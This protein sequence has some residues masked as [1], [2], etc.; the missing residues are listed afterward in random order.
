MDLVR[1]NAGV[2]GIIMTAEDPRIVA[3]DADQD[4]ASSF[5]DSLGTADDPIVLAQ[6]DGDPV[7]VP[8]GETGEGSG[9]VPI[10]AEIT[11]DDDNV[12]RLPSGVT[13]EELRLDGADIILVQA[14]GTEI[15]IINAALNIPTFVIDGIEVPQEVLVAVLGEN[16]INVAAGPE[17]QLTVVG[18]TPQGSGANFNDQIG[19]G[20]GDGGPGVLNL[21]QGTELGGGGEGGEE[22]TDGSGIAPTISAGGDTGTL[23]ESDDV[24][25][26]TDAEPVPATGTISFFDPDFG[27]TRTAEITART[28]ISSNIVHGPTLTAAQIDAL[29][30][31]FTLDSAASGGVTS[32]PSAAG[33]G[34]VDW[35]YTVANALIDF[36]AEGETIVLDFVVTISDGIND[37]PTT[38][39]ITV[40]G[41]NDI[42]VFTAAD[43]TVV[44]EEAVL[45]EGND[46]DS[47]G[48]GGSDTSPDAL[49]PFGGSL[50][51]T[52]GPDDYSDNA[53]TIV[54]GE[55]VF[56]GDIAWS[57]GTALTSR[58]ED[59][60]I[61]LSDGG[62]TITG[63]AG[64]RVVFIATV[65]EQGN[66]TYTFDLQDVLDHPEANAEDSVT[67]TFG[68]TVTDSND[69][70]QDHSFDV[71]INDDAPMIG[72]P[73]SALVDED[74]LTQPFDNAT[75]NRDVQPG[76]DFPVSDFS[77]DPDGD[78][79]R[80][81]VAGTLGIAWGADNQNDI[82]DGG[83]ETV[84]GPQDGDRAVTFASDAI[85]T[86]EALGLTSQGDDLEYTL[87]PN[88]TVLTAT[89]DDG[90]GPRTVFVVT[91]SDE[92]TGSFVFDLDD[93]LDHEDGSTEDNITLAFNFTVTD[94]DGDQVDGSFT[95]S[96]D[97]DGPV[98]GSPASALVDED[99]LTEPT[100]NATGNRD[101]QPGDDFPVSDFSV[102]PDGD[103]DRTTVA[104]RLDIAWGADDGNDNVDGG[105]TGAPVDGDRAVTF[106]SNA[107]STLEALV[108]T[109][110]GDEVNYALSDD[111]TTLLAYRGAA[112]MSFGDVDADQSI[113]VFRV[114]LS[115][116][117][118]GSY[119]FDLNDVLDHPDDSTEDNIELAFHFTATDS[120][121]DQTDGTFT[122]EVDDDSP[123]FADD[124]DAGAVDEDGLAGGNDGDSY[125][126]G[127]DI[128]G[129]ATQTVGNLNLAWGADDE[130]TGDG[131]VSLL[132][133]VDIHRQD[134]VEFGETTP[135]ADM[136]RAV[137]FSDASV[138][139]TGVGGPITDLTSRG[140]QVEFSLIESGTRLIAMAGGRLVFTVALSDDGTGSYTF[141]LLDELDHPGLDSEDNISLAFNITARDFDGD[142]A[143][144]QFTVTVNDD[145]PELDGASTAT[146]D[147]D[148]SSFVFI[149][150]PGLP[151]SLSGGPDDE[152]FPAG[153]IGLG[154]LGIDWGA[155]RSGGRS[156]A[157]DGIT[158][159]DDAFDASGNPLT[160]GGEQVKLWVD[161]TTLYGYVGNDPTSG[162]PAQLVFTVA[163]DD[164][165]ILN[166]QGSYSFVLNDNLDHAATGTE[167]E[168]TLSFDFRATDADGDSRVGS[169]DVVVDD[170][171]PTVG[172]AQNRTVDEDGG[173]DQ[174][175]NPGLPGSNAGGTD[176][177]NAPV[178]RTGSLAIS[179]GADR[180]NA[181]VNGGLTGAG[182]TPAD[183]DRAVA[184]DGGVIGSLE[185]LVLSSNGVGLAYEL[186]NGNST[187]TAFRFDGAN[188]IDGNGNSIGGVP[189]PDAA[190][191]TVELYDDSNSGSYRFTLHDNLDHAPGGDENEIELLF[192][193]VAYDS[194]GDSRGGDFEITIDD[195]TPIFSAT[196][197]QGTV[198]EDGLPE[199]IGDGQ[200]D[201]AVDADSDNDGDETTF[202][203]ALNIS[204]GAD[205]GD[206]SDTG[207][208]QD[209]P[210]GVGNRSVTFL[211]S[212]D[213]ASPAGLTSNGEQVTYTLNGDG[214]E[215]TASAGGRT[216]FTV[217]LSDDGA[218]TYS[219]TLLDNLDHAEGGDEND[220]PLAFGFT[221]AD[222]DGDTVDGSF[223]VNVDDDLPVIGGASANGVVEEEENDVAGPGIEDSDGSGDDDTF[224]IVQ[225]SNPTTHQ[226]TD[227][228]LNIDWGADDAN[229]DPD[230]G[231]SDGNGDRGLA[232]TNANAVDNITVNGGAILA[233][234]LTS[235]GDI[236]TYTFDNDRGTLIATADAGGTNERV[237]FT[238][239]LSDQGSGSYSFTLEDT[240][241]HP[242]GSGENTLTFTFA[243]TATDSDGD[244]ADST[245]SVEVI[246]DRPDAA[247]NLLP[248]Y[249]E[250]EALANGNEDV[251]PIGEEA[252]GVLYN[253]GLI[254]DEIGASLNIAWGGDDSNTAEN[255]GFD[256]S[257]A[258]GDRS[259]I[260]DVA[261]PA[262]TSGGPRVLSD[263]EINAFLSVSG[264]LDAS[265]LTSGGVALVYALSADNSVLTATAGSGGAV[266]FTVTLSDMGSG[267]WNF[268][269]DGTLDHPETEN[270]PDD[271]NVL[272]LSFDFAARDGDGDVSNA[273][274]AVRIIDDSPVMAGDVQNHQVDEDG[275][276]GNVGDSYAS[277][278]YATGGARDAATV[279]SRSL[280]IL[281]GA[282]N[283]DDAVD[284]A[285]GDTLLQDTRDG[286]GDRSVIFRN[287]TL[288][289]LPDL[290]SGGDDVHF[291]F[292]DDRTILVAHKG[293]PGTDF[294]SVNA[295]DL[296]FRVSL[297]D[298]GA[299][300]YSFEL[301][302]KLD[303]DE[304][305]GA[306]DEDNI[307]LDFNFRAFDS[308][309]D[310]I[311]GSFRVRVDD[312]APVATSVVDSAAVYESELDDGTDFPNGDDKNLDGGGGDRNYTGNL[313]DLVSFG[314]D[315]DGTYIVELTNLA[316]E[317]DALTSGGVQLEYSMNPI[318]SENMLIATANGVEIFNFQVN[319]VNGQYSFR[320]KGPID[321]T[322]GNDAEVV[323]DMSSAV[324]ARDSD[325]DTIALGGQI[326]ITIQDDV[327]NIGSVSN[328]QVFA[329]GF[330]T[331]SAGILD[332]TNG[333]SG[334]VQLFN[335]GDN[336][337]DTATGSGQYALI[338]QSNA[339]GG[340][341]GPFTRFEGYQSDFG[342]GFAA[343]I[344]IY[345][346]PAALAAGEGFDY[347]VAAYNQ[348]GGHLR[349][350]IFHVTK[351]TSTGELLVGG[352]NNTN[353]DPREDL[354]TLDH[355]QV[356]SAGWYR[357]EHVFRDAGDGSLAVD[358]NLYD[359]DGNL[360]FTE[361]RNNPADLIDILVGGHGYG[362]FTNIDVAG[363]IAVDDLMMVETASAPSSAAVGEAADGAGAFDPSTVAGVLG[364]DWGADNH[365]DDGATVDRSVSFDGVAT[366]DPVLSADGTPLT[367]NGVAIL[368]Q[369]SA[370]GTTLE[371]IADDD[372]DGMITGADTRVVFTVALDDGS[373]P[374][375]QGTWNFTLSDNVDH[376]SGG[377]ED[378]VV[379]IDFGFIATDADGDPTAPATFTVTINDDVPSAPIVTTG[380]DE[381]VT[382]VVTL[383][384]GVDFNFGADDVGAS[385]SIGAA[386]VTDGPV[387]LTLGLPAIG[388][389]GGD[390][391]TIT[392]GTAFDA[393]AE[394][395][396][397][398]L[399]IPYTVTDGD[400]DTATDEITVT[401]TGANDAPV[402]TVDAGSQGID[403]QSQLLASIAAG[404][405]AIAGI[406]ADGE[407]LA[408][409]YQP[410]FD[411]EVYRLVAGQYQLEQ[412][413]QGGVAA[414]DQF[415]L[416]LDGGT[417]I[418]GSNGYATGVPFR[419]GM[420]R[421][422][423]LD[424]ND[425]WVQTEE[426]FGIPSSEQS[427]GSSVAVDGDRI[428]VGALGRH[429]GHF[430]AG[431]VFI[432][433]K[434]AGG[435]WVQTV[436]EN[437]QPTSDDYL[438]ISIDLDGDRVI[439]GGSHGGANP[440]GTGQVYV[441]ERDAGGTWTPT[442]LVP[443]GVTLEHI[444]YD[445]AIEGD[446]AVI[447]MHSVSGGEG[448]VAVFQFTGGLWTQTQLL[449]ATPPEASAH[450]GF[451][452]DL[453]GG[454]LAIAAPFDD[455]GGSDRGLIYVYE[456]NAGT[457][458]FELV[459]TLEGSMPDDG[460]LLG[461]DSY[462]T[463][464]VDGNVIAVTDNNTSVEVF[465]DVAG[466]T[467][468][469]VDL[470]ESD[471]ALT[472][473]GTVTVT[474][475][476]VTDEVSLAVTDVT[477]GGTYGGSVA[478]IDFAA[479]FTLDPNPVV[480]SGDTSATV[481]WDFDSQGEAFDFL[482]VGETLTISYELVATDDSGAANDD[483]APQTV[484]ITITGTNDAPV[485]EASSDVA[486]SVVES[487][488]I[489]GVT[490]A[491][492]TGGLS[493]GFT[494]TAELASLGTN[495]DATAFADVYADV[496]VEVGGDDAA[497]IAVL[498]A[499]LDPLYPGA[500]APAN[501]PINEA[502][503]RLGAHYAGLL[504]SGQIGPLTEVIAKYTADNNGS[505]APDRMQSLHDNL[506]GNLRGSVLDGRFDNTSGLL[507]ELRGIVD[508]I[509]GV[510]DPLNDALLQRTYFSGN[511]IGTTGN[512]NTGATYDAN[513]GIVAK[514]TGTID[515]SDVDLGAGQQLTFSGNDAGA[516]GSFTIDPV[517]GEWTYVLNQGAADS[518]GEGDNP[519]EVFTV[520][521]EDEHGATDTVDVSVTVTGT[522]DAP[523][524]IE[525]GGDSLPAD[526]GDDYVIGSVTVSDVDSSSFT[527]EVT[528]PDGSPNTD[529]EVVSD[530]SGGYQLQT[531][532]SVTSLP[533]SITI[534][535]D[536]GD[537]GTYSESFVITL[538]VQLFA[539]DQTTLLGSYS[540]IQAAVDDAGDNEFIVISSGTYTEQ[541]VVDGKT[542]LTIMEAPGAD[543][544]I[545]AP[546]DVV[547]TARSS[548][549]REIHS[550]VTVKNS[551]DIEINGV[552]VDG[553]GRANAID[554]GAGAGQANFT[555]VI[556][557]NASGGLTDVDITGVRDPY[558]GGTTAG[559]HDLV[560]GIQ[561]GVALQVDNDDTGPRLAFSM[562]GGSIADFQKNATSFVHADLDI[563]GVVITGGGAQ[564][565]IAQN[566]IQAMDSTGEITGVTITQIG[567]A[568]TS[569]VYSGGM[570]LYDNVD[571]DVTGSTIIGANGE[572]TAAKIVGIYVLNNG[573][574]ID[575]GEISGNSVS[576]V[577]Y[578][579]IVYG[580]IL[581]DQVN[582]SANTV[583]D[584]D[585]TNNAP[586]GIYHEPNAA[587]TT[588]FNVEGSDQ[589]DY[590]AGAAGADT[591]TGLDGDDTLDGR[592]G[593]DIVDGGAGDDTIMWRVGDGGDTIDGGSGDENIGDTLVVESTAPG[594]TIT[595]TAVGGGGFTVFDGTDTV[596]VENVEEV[597][598]DFSAGAGTLN[599]VGDF[600]A[601]GINI[602][603]ITVEGSAGNDTV[604]A[605]EM[606]HSVSTS[607][608]GI[609]FSGNGG[610]DT[611]VSGT[612]DDYFDGGD[613]TDSHEFDA[614]I[615]NY[616]VILNPDGTATITD[617]VG[618][619][620]VD[621]S[622][623]TVERIVFN[624]VTLDLTMAVRLFDAA[625]DSLL[626]TFDSVDDAI[627]AVA[628]Q[629]ATDLRIEVDG[630]EYSATESLD[631]AGA[632]INGKNVTIVGDGITIGEATGDAATL[633]GDFGGGSL[634]FENLTIDGGDNGISADG[635]VTGLTELKLDG[636]TVTGNA[637]HGLYLFET[638]DGIALLTIDGG[639]FTGNGGHD[640]N[641][642]HIKLFGFSGDADFTGG[643]TLDGTAN[644]PAYGIEIVGGTQGGNAN[645]V[646]ANEP[647]IG[648]VTFNGV[649]LTGE[650]AKNAVA[651]YN[652]LNLN[653]L[654]IQDLDLSGA[655]AGWEALFNIDGIAASYDASGYNITYPDPGDANFPAGGIVAELQGDKSGQNP[656]NNT[657]T[658]GDANERLIGKEGN[659]TLYG[660]GGDDELYG[661]YKPHPSNPDEPGND[662]L[663]GGAGNDRMFGGSGDDTFMLI[664]SGFDNG[665]D[666]FD[667]GDGYDRILGG[668]S[669]DVLNVTNNLS[670]LVSIEEIDGASNTGHNTI[671][672]TAGDDTLDF[673]SI[674][675]KQFIIDGAGGNDTITGTNL[676]DTIR[677]GAG[678]DILNGLDGD[679]TFL[680]VTSNFDNGV[681]QYDGGVGYDRIV[682]GW[683]ID[684]LNVTNNLAN[685]VGI[686][687]LEGGDTTLDRNTILATAGNDTLN[688]S[689]M[690]VNN[691]TIDGGAGNDNITGTSAGDRIRGGA[692]NDTITGGA[693]NDTL[694][695][696]GGDDT[697]VLI[698]SGFDN[699]LD[700]Y[701]GGTGYDRIVGGW[702]VDVL[703]VT[704]NLSNLVSIEELDGA[705]SSNTILATTG[706][707]T[708][709]F[710]SILVKNFTIDGGA[711][712]DTITGTNLADTIR[713]GADNDTLHGL[714]G[715]DT[716]LLNTGGDL[717][718]I[719]QY[720]GG[721][722]YDRI[723]GGW[724]IDV[725]HVTNNLA[726]LVGI[727]AVDGGDA[728]LDRNTILATGGN[729]TLDFSGL[730][731]TRFTIDGGAGDDNITGTDGNDR[732][733]GGADNDEIA[734]GAGDDTLF[735]NDGDDT[736]VGGGAPDSGADRM[737]GGAGNDTI[738]GNET[739]LSEAAN[740]F[741]QAGEGDIASYAGN[742][743]DY[744]VT[745]N[746]GLEAW[747]VTRTS[748]G[749][750]GAGSVD[751]LYGIE[752][753][754][755]GNNGTV[756]IDLTAA[757]QLFDDAGSLLG[758]F[759]HIQDAIDAAGSVAG[760]ATVRVAAGTYEEL[761]SIDGENLTLIGEGD[762]TVIV[763]PPGAIPTTIT[764]AASGTPDK[765][766][767]ITVE[768][769]TVT[770]QGIKIDGQGRGDERA[771][772]S[773]DFDGI[774]MINS[775]GT[776]EDVTITGIRAPLDG[777]DNVSGGQWGVGFYIYN[778]DGSPRSLV[779]T[780]NTVE[781][782]QKNATVFA[783]SGLNVDV[784]GNTIT[785]N[786]GTPTTA[787]NGLQF[788]TGV[789]GTVDSNTVQ[790]IGWFYSGT[791][792]QWTSSSILSN[793]ADV[794]IT[795]NVVTGPT[796][797]PTP[798]QILSAT[799]I[800][801]ISDPDGSVLQ[802]NTVT[803][804]TWGVISYLDGAAPTIDGNSF[805][806]DALNLGFYDPAVGVTVNGS[807]GA[808]EFDGGAGD[809]TFNGQGGNDTFYHT[810]GE[811]NDTIDGGAGDT[812]TFTA[813]GEAGVAETFDIYSD[814]FLS[815]PGNAALAA[816]LGYAA[817]SAE[818]IIARN[819][820]V[821]TELSNIEEIVID[822]QGGAD[823]FNV[824]GTFAGTS[825]ATST[826]TI[827]GGT[828][829]DTVDVS[830]LASAHRV[831]LRTNGGDDVLL[832][833]RADD[834]IDVGGRTPVSVREVSPGVYQATMDDGSTV[835]Y[836]GNAQFVDGN[837]GALN[838]PPV[839]GD[840]ALTVDEDTV[841]H[842]DV[843][844]DNGSGIDRDL[845]AGTLTVSEVNGSAAGVGTQIALASGALL[846]LQ[847]DGT[848]AY[849]QNGAF[850]HLGGADTGAD[851]FTYTV[852][853]GQGG[854][855]TATAT[856]TIDGGNDAP[857]LALNTI[858]SGNVTENFSGGVSGGSGWAN[859]WSFQGTGN[860]QIIGGR[861]RLSDGDDQPDYAFRTVDL[862]GVD[863][864][865]LT[866]DYQ[867]QHLDVAGDRASVHVRDA[868][869]NWVLIYT[870]QGPDNDSGLVSTGPIDLTPYASANTILR[871]TAHGSLSNES[872]SQD[873]IYLDNINIAYTKT[874]PATDH[875]A[876]Y[877]EGSA[878]VS[879]AAA[880]PTI[881]DADG[882]I[883]Q[884][885]TVVLTNAQP[886]DKLSVGAL[887][888]GIAAE[889]DGSAPGVI[890][891]TLTGPASHADFAAAIEAVTFSNN[892]QNPDVTPRVVEVTV[893]D[894][895]ADS[896]V[897]TTTIN[898]TL[899]NSAPETDDIAD[900]VA[901]D[902]ALQ[903]TLQG[904]DSD[905]TVA[906][907][908]ITTPPANGVLSA[909]A[910][911][912]SP[913][914]PDNIPAS[915]NATALWFV[916]DE[917]FHG[918]VTFEYVAV[919]DGGEEDPSPATATISV[920]PVNDAPVL[921]NVGGTV[922]YT[923]NDPATVVDG[924]ITLTDVDDTMIEGATVS[925]IGSSG[926]GLEFLLFDPTPNI[927]G[928]FDLN[929]EV[930]TLSGSATKA[931][932]ET[933]L[934]S[935]RYHSTDDS[936]PPGDRFLEFA[937]SDGD[938]TSNVG[939]VTVTVV[940]AEDE[941]IIENV[942]GDSVS[943]TEGGSAIAID[944]GGNALVSDI[945]SFDFNNGELV[946]TIQNV[947]AGDRLTIVNGGGIIVTT[948]QLPNTSWLGV[949]SY[950]G[951]QF[952]QFTATGPNQH[953]MGGTLTIDLD[954]D[955]NPAAVQ[956]LIRALRYDNASQ[957]PDET[958]REI[959]I[960]LSDGDGGT[961]DVSTVTVQVNGVNDGDASISIT[962]TVELGETLTAIF[963]N[964]D[965]DGAASGVTYQWQRGGVDIGGA[966]GSTYTLVGADAFKT[967]TVAVSYTDGQ[968]FTE[969][970]VSA[971]TAPVVDPNFSVTMSFES[972]E[973]V[974]GTSYED[975]DVVKYD[976]ITVS[977]VFSEDNFITSQ[978][979]NSTN[980][981]I[982][983]A[984]VFTGSGT[985]LGHEY[986]DGYMLLSV[987]N[988]AAALPR[989]GGPGAES[990]GDNDVVLWFSDLG[991]ARLIFTAPRG[992]DAVSVNPDNGNLIFSVESSYN[993]ATLGL[994]TD[995][996]LIEFDGTN[997]TKFFD[998]DD[999]FGASNSFEGFYND[1000]NI[1001][1002]VHVLGSNE[1003]ILSTKGDGEIG[1004]ISFK[1005]G[1006][1007]VH[1008]D[1009]T[1010]AT[1011]ILDEATFFDDGDGDI[1012]AVDPS[1013]ETLEMLMA[1014]VVRHAPIME[1015]RQV[1016]ATSNNNQFV[1017]TLVAAALAAEFVTS[1018]QIDISAQAA[1019]IDPAGVVIADGEG[1020]AI[1021]G[1022]TAVVSA[1023]GKTLIVSLPEG[1024][1025]SEGGTI[1026]LDIASTDGST[1027]SADDAT[1028]SITFSDGGT[1029]DGGYTVAADGTG[1030][1031]TVSAEVETGLSIQ[1032]TAGDDV[1033]IGTDGDDV[1034][1035]GLG[1036][1037]DTLV[1038]GLGDD[1039]L[1040]GGEGLNTLTGGDGADTF[1041]IDP[1042]ALSE[1043][1044]MVDIIAD[1045]D[1046]SEGDTVDLGNLLDD[1047]FGAGAPTDNAG[1048]DAV[1049]NLRA[1050]GGNTD[1051]VIDT[1052]GTPTGEVVVAQLTGV[1053]TA[1054]NILYDNGTETE[1055]V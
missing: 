980:K 644:T 300:S 230:G 1031:A 146:V 518:L 219:F 449:T 833:D 406:A 6:A 46:G 63:T 391:I 878:A 758:T 399:R 388:F 783:G 952:G 343:S 123:V 919:D 814:A 245:F 114:T 511:E 365:D 594:Q 667:G 624:D 241:E 834:V 443:S 992:L 301:L 996:D 825:L 239:S 972:N 429:D 261:N 1027:I 848:F 448:A 280:N 519:V 532:G 180:D 590:L 571:L 817:G 916:P 845:D 701:D 884:S 960:T 666:H 251:E 267:S 583:F 447:G 363:G 312:D 272:E 424:S 641:T 59:I 677:G 801:V 290:T 384:N 135:N 684:V 478:G 887:P 604:D 1042:S 782:F 446:I 747:Q 537:G 762:A 348:S 1003:I 603:T 149:T 158:N 693:G 437:P 428:A 1051:V 612:G 703:N 310:R 493:H 544:T 302:G 58:G 764:V 378:N 541:V 948:Q 530:G 325:G 791:G 276:S 52:W 623:E 510:I 467:G 26:G 264:S 810:V 234:D 596:N 362:W 1053:H 529:L 4:R 731:V 844:A 979:T 199:G 179:W 208:V 781:D 513:N 932:Y 659:D 311:D 494:I 856:V 496:L 153:T 61:T 799:G 445:V 330:D 600:A 361:T 395:E 191:F 489:A 495:A 375:D 306:N 1041:V 21:L 479:M 503:V 297:S 853:D 444:G 1029:L 15:R 917:N 247:G 636:V 133:L 27:E 554:E 127:D 482:G 441:W 824:H 240:I 5:E 831:V 335:S 331:D 483:S 129:N 796:N 989:K 823:T 182:L 423:E 592:G 883:L 640:N 474:D 345:L 792:T 373:A 975:G 400:G 812:D 92:N 742:A 274:F 789:T 451:S 257:Q 690:V 869:S 880:G 289:Q 967:I 765:S 492:P 341:T 902:G 805:A 621:T 633:S 915:G 48:A 538:P 385:V 231:D 963:G 714:D 427:F 20:E 273:S 685:L 190:V 1040:I 983:G 587:L 252:Q 991:R 1001:D 616:S 912:L 852:V 502:F 681:D 115:D 574:A 586:L 403:P 412:T 888:G 237:V 576:Q 143:T 286:D 168:I 752:G 738:Y 402:I 584:L 439:A 668:W 546:A 107:I 364:I 777:N 456:F 903:I 1002:A 953:D 1011:V 421:I 657:I 110:S 81:T 955:A 743:S 226:A 665:L 1047:A 736:L 175:A 769:S 943:F 73:A 708:L 549:D 923:E 214:T 397:A 425:D 661:H 610:D 1028:F 477:T 89:A 68:L 134:G 295:A 861:M 763:A 269:L 217:S 485:I 193:Y 326:L 898:I 836:T 1036:G 839:A 922:T 376:P 418:A 837:G 464:V 536:D 905:G 174:T 130:D 986:N 54:N 521:V 894:G 221:A 646:P 411:I 550:V 56:T 671:L 1017:F 827:E 555:G 116:V 651:L 1037:N 488:S 126:G 913:V 1044:G 265:D 938:A 630:S 263:A 457:G 332:E 106:A 381:N 333:W 873:R 254:T 315:D 104:G 10:P 177:A 895:S 77:V 293:A 350:F 227:V 471:A 201:D 866:F 719:D 790:E 551:T 1049:V 70:A 985:I 144:S 206:V 808:D 944:Q 580:N 776:I 877:T 1054:I 470:T 816:A 722:G 514:A 803:G 357:F 560:S 911:G 95:V 380:M 647:A 291:V 974:N 340:L 207:G 620:G 786:G 654:E 136:G 567:Y 212:L 80:T 871:I 784:S 36:L 86:L 414:L 663:I 1030:T 22:I 435:N 1004:G 215:L 353:F 432:Y 689:S 652:F 909:T 929:T 1016:E 1055:V 1009:G 369:L 1005:D 210:T 1008:W 734:G 101:V 993:D 374:A 619:D 305:D 347:S 572:S 220:I 491:G 788:S 268:N 626:G 415:R 148:G 524:D 34:T 939:T 516:Y 607:D 1021:D 308:D 740:Q 244:E 246:D 9:N 994:I 899:V 669:I 111:G 664:T 800:Y 141:T 830:A 595:L 235:R 279:A 528:N 520:T 642:A 1015:T 548:S 125:V 889:V 876:N 408:V 890:T 192:N 760:H 585:G 907:F 954:G 874:V 632:N 282:D 216:V 255:G 31:G 438:G 1019:T 223:T 674:L 864:A 228:D 181:T 981:N 45:A 609:D 691:F 260:F 338:N 90:S 565:I 304:V 455:E 87:S 937:V 417:L 320:L 892:S 602:N 843:F 566:G 1048:A 1012:N 356:N 390:T 680:L 354:E 725:L 540:T 383:V 49:P 717:S 508:G 613:G 918:S 486:G 473:S 12:V 124:P 256:G 875:T 440:S 283:L 648:D 218:G 458:Q 389:S 203:G 270:G 258:P 352:S 662:T 936:P 794:D 728:T 995:G 702:S 344:G 278:D 163:L 509:D 545:Q 82:V 854:T 813:T 849:D 527:F 468:S 643:L 881:S 705:G 696:N 480:G 1:T 526:S 284:G 431:R 204:W 561:R 138:E 150:N 868:N 401:V 243:F 697:F 556:Y 962:G 573:G 3:S 564:T 229:T 416:A 867:R 75:G 233:A 645:P 653:G 100:D 615:A 40:V 670:N 721:A 393:L 761:L 842:G 367:S 407:W 13:I 275:L 745:W 303:H 862:S 62:Q 625:N 614:N 105:I 557:R 686:E 959:T 931:E 904:S 169:F 908:R 102:D 294:A 793:G 51:I 165:G 98:I 1043:I 159:G 43:A 737:I 579:I 730:E 505:G 339:A 162:A 835:T 970:V 950:N 476:D 419:S 475:V 656:V 465:A 770:I 287:N 605:S 575:G 337:I 7:P 859:N 17:G 47:Y 238:V 156:V 976:G 828:G 947:A 606:V 147:E 729:D 205:D 186:T 650:F 635:T 746:A 196:P 355:H 660:G 323:L 166:P 299:G 1026:S 675:V 42:P 599:V 28:L 804:F 1045:Y 692:D 188:Y 452:V 405:Q 978:I 964:D 498:W 968:G 359:P 961:S 882:T 533:A 622:S 682:G 317:L 382:H 463:V 202:T 152:G 84:A 698:T 501:H 249:V 735:G 164:G 982:D 965:P 627:N 1034:L 988:S 183:G 83:I 568:G 818:I 559:G 933:V 450:F 744:A 562:S 499:H 211:T 631:I 167:D 404:G 396:T 522:N 655:T 93:A 706:N 413:L 372:N 709:D 860:T 94:S 39:R 1032:G 185:G 928:S 85:T 512:H 870:I 759:E 767:I 342:T 242:E 296:V 160:A 8:D 121:G 946:V 23:V 67:L 366:N 461:Y 778:V 504:A 117:D 672:A 57:N 1025:V 500:A 91:L 1050:N 601:S 802:S 213:G 454:V 236:I 197:Q 949:L 847:A 713:G 434:D 170:D 700:H 896:N 1035:T 990:F 497:A 349:D 29:L 588:L 695:G 598:V 920:T 775:G 851:S 318:A 638:R 131:T 658:G 618:D 891:V 140:D 872:G 316:P 392:P 897:A 1038:G 1052:D 55:V 368:Y 108:L 753:I 189:G 815:D 469:G 313:S 998:E 433:D 271:E 589:N 97:D 772:G 420:V 958:D 547:E 154:S 558:P 466:G 639:S 819:D 934:R 577:D 683:S 319:P 694:F 921:S 517:T 984:H 184:F 109:S 733:R 2:W 850:D 901:E 926:E 314:A 72:S 855:A 410:S 507:D 688:F 112:G 857:E 597:T 617:N 628:A 453:E 195:D 779:F 787:Q 840:D 973:T 32:E 723:V 699:G 194:D 732:I 137:W 634:T 209:T 940:G 11:P 253:L 173:S 885:A 712:N 1039:T 78:F 1033:L 525:L 515:A 569:G 65:D 829:D 930:L 523:H 358:L 1007:L 687:E 142:E 178:S 755:F 139:V 941:P 472:T 506:L 673:S 757:V 785:G 1014:N 914:D 79:N 377:S 820:N 563:D 44:D 334:T 726:N 171:T 739:D 718:G 222:S 780:N 490:E 1024:A 841:L 277:G 710:S 945:D 987:S 679:D 346:D 942:D 285:S 766:A 371:G 322:G 1022:A 774:V 422:F 865:T 409:G 161:G 53:Q 18:P 200:T 120:D 281:W 38:V 900:S 846:T 581:P 259:V 71:T 956:A 145:A 637:N 329:Q 118:D 398:I 927:T 997:Y 328:T 539:P 442:E 119:V 60:E 14:D 749:G 232:F 608:V 542:G 543:V 822:G 1023:D 250:E 570:L 459:D 187:L 879:I 66:G 25:G 113:Q 132:G 336:G 821:I 999:G 76:D 37:V 19:D 370:D 288:N 754:D 711:G 462:G 327:P 292:N 309:G 971:A 69:F 99:A 50:G 832:G 426:L 225:L 1013:R 727:E 298:E 924:D 748:G 935:V 707:D 925:L 811:G 807:D 16:G 266:V 224:F 893:N 88:G 96:V 951:V 379:A 966:N 716:F 797:D 74:A 122:V 535:A 481:G 484:T 1046:K 593:A 386:S 582:L 756:D 531:T 394:G 41:T 198:D 24:P 30:A 321:H 611:F 676:A 307:T 176:D 157:F 795:N 678:N 1000:V 351:D 1006:D 806:D 33:N 957:N 768:D 324:T 741:V 773:D 64:G 858:I 262:S 863:S 886:D 430:W 704:N 128:P 1018:I 649:V 1010:T 977:E 387:G 155:D 826:I 103:T 591:L 460:D 838:L 172:N 724:S 553:D 715:D 969:T 534:T 751:T 360:V 629:G 487:G 771:A 750:E 248:R 798:P 436:L 552:T 720:D 809:D 906:H 35:T 151:G 910:D 578:G 1020:N